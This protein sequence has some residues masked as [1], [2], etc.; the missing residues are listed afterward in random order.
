MKAVMPSLLPDIQAIRKKTGADQ[1][2]EMWDGVLH[3]PPAPNRG[4][5]DL[6][7]CLES[8]LRS[9]WA[10]TCEGKVYHQINVAA[11]GGWPDNYRIPDLVLL[12]P[13]RFAIDRNEYFEGA[14]D[15]VV[16]IHSPGDEAY[17]KLPFYGDLGVPEVWIIHRDT[18]EPEIHVLKRN[19]Y[20]KQP[21]SAQ[22]WIRSPHLKIE[23]AG[24]NG[25]LAVRL[26]GDDSTRQELPL[27]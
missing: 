15:V 24:A 12:L 7:F 21:A 20:K 1:W 22:G 14:P 9:Y 10:P 4:H 2:D 25:K 23:M 18:R 11:I 8:Y 27:D 6:E 3:M 16:E 19:R 26:A 5:Q 13:Q 17:E